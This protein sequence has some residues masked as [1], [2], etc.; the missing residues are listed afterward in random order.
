MQSVRTVVR[1]LI[2]VFLATAGAVLAAP[3]VRA[4]A[5]GIQQS[6]RTDAASS[7]RLAIAIDG[8]SPDFATPASTVTV[9][10]TL[11]NHTGSAIA[12]LIVQLLTSPS[13]F[14]TRSGMDS[15]AA[16]GNYFNLLVQ[17]TPYTASGAL[18]EGATVHWTVSFSPAQA[19][20]SV[21]G[22]YPLALTNPIFF[23]VNGNGRYDPLHAHGSH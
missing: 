13:P 21:F 4:H 16:S 6:S 8:M 2:A 20:Y 7:H 10:G 14:S 22:V 17:G 18:A 3:A 9:R 15:F 1:T 12:G 23:D 19:Q 11:T 5:Q